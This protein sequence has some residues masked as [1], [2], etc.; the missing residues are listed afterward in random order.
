MTDQESNKYYAD[1]AL[2][3]YGQN[4]QLSDTDK[5][6]QQQALDEY[7]KA[8]VN[9]PGL[10][11]P[12][13]LS[14]NDILQRKQDRLSAKAEDL[15][16]DDSNFMIK[17]KQ[18]Y[19]TVNN[20]W[21]GQDLKANYM[22][23]EQT[24]SNKIFENVNDTMEESQAKKQELIDQYNN[25]EDDPN[26]RH[27]VYQL[28]LLDG[29]D[30]SGNPIYTYKTGIAE[31]S[32]AERYKN[33]YIKNGY[34]VLSEKGFAGAEDWENQWHGLK[35]N[36]ADRVFDEG[37]N[38]KGQNIKSK[39]N[40]GE[41]YSEIYGTQNFN[42]GES[43]KDIDANK[44]RSKQLSDL[45]QQQIAQG[46][47]R[48]SDSIIKALEAGAAKTVLDT[49]DTALDIA[50]PGNNTW[51]DKYKEQSAIDKFVGYNRK[52]ADKA[53]G[54]AIGYF[55]QGKYANA[56]WEVLKEPQMVA[57]SIPY[58]AMMTLGTGKFTVA[59]KAM[60]E[61]NA[62]KLTGDAAL[63]AEKESKLAND[64]SD[65]SKAMYKVA[66]N[67]GFLTTVASTTNND[68]DERLKNSSNGEGASIPE[69]LGVF[70]SNLALLG[71]D[72]I[73]FDKITGIEGGK[74][75][76]SDAFAFSDATGK[77]KIL[78]G[79]K[80][81]ALDLTEAGATEAAQEYIQGWG[82]IINQQLGTNKNNGDLSKI[83]SSQENIDN[84]IGGMLAGAAGGIHMRN[85]SDSV[86][87]TYNTITGKSAKEQAI[88]DIEE[89]E[90][91]SFTANKQYTTD[92]E[93]FKNKSENQDDLSSYRVSDEAKRVSTSRIADAMFGKYEIKDID[94][95]PVE[96]EVAIGN[97]VDTL[98]HNNM[99]T[100][101][102]YLDARKANIELIKNDSTLSD[103]RKNELFD[104]YNENIAND[105]LARANSYVN[106]FRDTYNNTLAKINKDSR[107]ASDEDKLKATQIAHEAFM[108]KVNT[109][110]NEYIKNRLLS[111][112]INENISNA[113]KNTFGTDAASGSKRI[114]SEFEN[115]TE[116]SKDKYINELKEINK[117][118][119]G[120]LPE[121]T[122]NPVRDQL[123]LSI[124]EY[125]KDFNTYQERLKNSKIDGTILKVKTVDDV[126]K[127]IT[128]G[129][130]FIT[131]LRNPNKK[132]INGYMTDIRK[133]MYA[134]SNREPKKIG[135]KED[136]TNVSSLSKPVDEISRFGNTRTVGNNAYDD[137][138][139]EYKDAKL[140]AK[141]A[142][143]SKKI[144]EKLGA[145]LYARE[146]EFNKIREE[147]ESRS[148]NIDP[149]IQELRKK[150]PVFR[151]GIASKVIA[152]AML[153][154]GQSFIDSLNESKALLSAEIEKRA[155]TSGFE[156]LNKTTKSNIDKSIEI[157]Q[158]KIEAIDEAINAQKYNM[159]KISDNMQLISNPD[160]RRGMAMAIKSSKQDEQQSK[161]QYEQEQ[162]QESTKLTG[163]E[164]EQQKQEPI[165]SKQTES[166]TEVVPEI[167]TTIE[168][169]PIES[170]SS[171][172]DTAKEN[173]TTE[174][175]EGSSTGQE[176][177]GTGN[178]T[179]ET[180][181]SEAGTNETGNPE[182]SE[183]I[184]QENLEPE[185][186]ELDRLNAEIKSLEQEIKDASKNIASGSERISKLERLEKA[187]AYV[188]K[189]LM[190]SIKAI[191]EL[192]DNIKSK[193]QMIEDINKELDGMLSEQETANNTETKKS[194]IGRLLK[195]EEQLSAKINSI[196]SET[197]RVNT[198]LEKLIAMSE[199]K[200]LSQK[201][202]NY[203]KS[204]I[205]DLKLQREMIKYNVK[206]AKD[207]EIT[208]MYSEYVKAEK[209]F[210]DAKESGV[211]VQ[212][213]NRLEYRVKTL[214]RAYKNEVTIY[215]TIKNNALENLE[216]TLSNMIDKRIETTLS[217]PE[218]SKLDGQIKDLSDSVNKLKNNMYQNLHDIKDI[219]YTS[220][221]GKEIPVV[222]DIFKT[223][224]IK[225]Y[226]ALDTDEL[227]GNI[228]FAK[229]ENV[230]K[231]LTK[232]VGKLD[233]TKAKENIDKL[234]ENYINLKGETFKKK[235]E[236]EFEVIPEAKQE[237]LDKVTEPLKYIVNSNF[238]N[239]DVK[240]KSFSFSE[241]A[242]VYEN[243]KQILNDEAKEVLKNI[244]QYDKPIF[245]I[246]NGTIIAKVND[247][248]VNREILNYNIMSVLFGTDN[249]GYA[250]IP[251]FAQDVI[252][253][254]SLKEIENMYSLLLTNPYTSDGK[255]FDEIWGLDSYDENIDAMRD[256]VLDN[257]VANGMI[258]ESVIVRKL[259]SRIYK[260]LPLSFNKST[261]ELNT[262][263]E[264]ITQLGL[265]AIGQYSNNPIEFNGQDHVISRYKEGTLQEQ[266]RE[267]VPVAIDTDGE[268]IYKENIGMIRLPM[269][270]T[271]VKYITDVS[272]MLA[273]MGNENKGTKPSFE[274]I[275]TVSENIKNKK[276][277]KSEMSIDT[278][279][280]YQSIEYKFTENI[281]EM[282]NLW[283]DE[284]TR[285]K[286]Y[287]FADIYEPNLENMTNSEIK[288]R[289][290]KNRNERLEMDAMMR[291]YEEAGIDRGFY[292]PWDFVASG[293]YMISSNVNPQSSKI[294][295]FLVSTKGTRT[296]I[297]FTKNEGGKAIISDDILGGVKRSLAQSLDYGLD[298]DLDSVVIAKME[299]DFVVNNDG[300]IEFKDTKKAK[301]ISRVYDYYSRS[302]NTGNMNPS[303]VE[304]EHIKLLNREGEGFHGIQAIRELARLTHEFKIANTP[305]SESH[306]YDAHFVIEADGITSGMMITL[307]QMM[308]KNA[309]ELFEKGGIYSE[310]A[311]S[312][313]T[314][315]AKALGLENELE[316][317][318]KNS[319]RTQKITHG[320]LSH[321]G[322]ML[323]TRTVEPDKI[324][325]RTKMM[326]D[327]GMNESEIKRAQFQD[328]YNTVAKNVQSEILNIEREIDENIS[329]LKLSKTEKESQLESLD[330]QKK[331]INFIGT[332][333]DRNMAKD[334][335]MVFIYGSS[336]G[337]IKNRI[338][339]NLI[340]EKINKKL[341]DISKDSTKIDK[342]T[343]D[344]L[345]L[346]GIHIEKDNNGK[347]T[348][349][350]ILE[351]KFKVA[352]YVKN[353]STGET[354]TEY[355][356]K[357]N[358]KID[359][360]DL[361]HIVLDNLVM[362]K[363]SKES[364][365]TYG[366]A[367]E[368]SFD[369][370]F[371]FISDYR[372]SIKALEVIRFQVFDYKF[373]QKVEKLIAEKSYTKDNEYIKYN[374]NN[375]EL[376][377]IL[378]ELISEGYGHVIRDING[379]YHSFEKSEK[380][381][382]NKRTSVRFVDTKAIKENAKNTTNEKLKTSNTVSGSLDIKSEV[383]NTGAA[384]VTS[385][386][387]QDGWQI[388]YAT[389]RN[390]IQNVF[391]AIITGLNNHDNGVY[392]YNEGFSKANTIHSII[393]SQ[394]IDMEKMIDKLGVEEFGDLLSKIDDKS[395]E[396]II[397]TFNKMQSK[398]D[399][400]EF[401]DSK[402][403]VA[404][405]KWYRIKKENKPSTFEI[406]KIARKNLI[407][408]TNEIL[409]AL[410]EKV[411]NVVINH[412]YATDTG[413]QFK[414]SLGGFEKVEINT[415]K[416]F[417]FY[418][419]I[420]YKAQEI[421]DPNVKK[422]S[423]ENK[424]PYTRENKL[425]KDE[426]KKHK[427][428]KELN[429]TLKYMNLESEQKVEIE[430]IIQTLIN[431]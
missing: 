258:P 135:N 298:K 357:E 277:K 101:K 431:C 34:E 324:A 393:Q 287:M 129:A 104:K 232:G 235:L 17:A 241:N 320:L 254:E 326:Y 36:I 23:K 90:K 65:A 186:S 58:M 63:I 68:L 348:G 83:L 130:G 386:H 286:A 339:N 56:L 360:K 401:F 260:S 234:I 179:E 143:E 126:A 372:D 428:L 228:K 347:L 140:N 200:K 416:V 157:L 306:K 162:N 361:R 166:S 215:N 263:S 108:N 271:I 411:D 303:L 9:I 301:I 164:N 42:F 244:S 74:K 173:G 413:E 376:D 109:E 43:Q 284:K 250:K 220:I 111:D 190:D 429:A 327:A 120:S 45:K 189:K 279:L 330:R 338:L 281:K 64:V 317:L 142:K 95:N 285:D 22:G 176:E 310:E 84:A 378:Q 82:E 351:G 423:D 70:A 368:N 115:I 268:F 10:S 27:K 216:N 354:D 28:R 316:T 2:A 178:G 292:L 127:E 247:K 51:L 199:N 212:E 336:L 206:N 333:I 290:A 114:K 245:S 414:G 227:K 406:L 399:L 73:A 363:L 155:N 182:T 353:K 282:Y 177:V 367:F 274:P 118:Y 31:T 248:K 305:G 395:A 48:G 39:S 345:E 384:A 26:A 146:L 392:S 154:E 40:F 185:V 181:G 124:A 8:G 397:E 273:Y 362:Q 163:E 246:E 167:S 233:G 379:G 252:K 424:S 6:Y 4:T 49:A 231:Q 59:G 291:F 128:S 382:M 295:R 46:Y 92:S 313:W 288:K 391:D 98:K 159:S 230:Y 427:I 93:S 150:V 265:F 107:N 160:V 91:Y 172:S 420:I 85:A 239:T 321:I 385:I 214:N 5:Y 377:V 96:P 62:A 170:V 266:I 314:K 352:K 13:R 80:N 251:Q 11:E 133:K 410:S 139:N 125:E 278:I 149:M 137:I 191:T 364:Y 174:T 346:L 229:K 122:E 223:D 141:D 81:K 187:Y 402:G 134:L 38:A 309:Q 383:V 371:G 113:Y 319:D 417:N 147:L 61:L 407:S 194:Y 71:L 307:A 322:K 87:N 138:I 426:S 224:A 375:A 253:F 299:K 201:S 276:T 35:A 79:I 66:N 161:Q 400:N 110:P 20:L 165:E 296:E 12:E 195:V 344:I 412:L 342:Q 121:G 14:Q 75:A 293:R 25:A 418:N 77:K 100:P 262:E 355:I 403:K 270:M 218:I 44:I 380:S 388:R 204:K 50:T 289:L 264:I 203:I 337:S 197:I 207:S 97:V 168:Q 148:S 304:L 325:S 331:L 33:Q 153:K 349:K 169:E 171:E 283:K 76:L 158:K 308:T 184:V 335:V 369:N 318:G 106:D 272:S 409:E 358:G 226:Y 398:K 365:S 297:E 175:T 1:Q 404:K 430:D 249:E 257:F 7:K 188:A 151:V 145:D 261:I 192:S 221:D 18:A 396:S 370:N 343:V 198:N 53:T 237:F 112:I 57:E 21:N 180:N 275:T 311:V 24:M 242:Y 37:T 421:V 132:S 315:T 123:R 222:R 419:D 99:T 240:A 209:E 366:Q 341:F 422:P 193:E 3:E 52:S 55:K 103:E 89:R 350:T 374:P 238:V 425:A 208:R 373:K 67:A 211:Q 30:A 300:T 280:D 196:T 256:Y 213:L 359:N 387:N 217:E 323:D 119:F 117:K 47:G 152:D 202:I 219:A 405:D 255:E 332:T 415:D 329:E 156:K 356:S 144:D 54:E 86:E 389:M 328:F 60:S 210:N 19:N 116:A 136:L 394:M 390:G 267:S 105:T 131:S 312:F 408:N 72:R 78:E 225:S 183:Q 32:A 29:Y 102:K 302:I 16:K 236:K 294:T 205:N 334:P 269:D 381:E 243:G 69:V 340:K 15:S 41:G 94:N 88:R 259:G